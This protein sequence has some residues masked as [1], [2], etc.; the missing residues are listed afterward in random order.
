VGG[1]ESL[2]SEGAGWGRF[3]IAPAGRLDFWFGVVGRLEEEVEEVCDMIVCEEG[4]I[5]RVGDGGDRIVFRYITNDV[6][7]Y[8]AIPV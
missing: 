8:V 5:A 4:C 2:A 7:K 1:P 6:A 3:R